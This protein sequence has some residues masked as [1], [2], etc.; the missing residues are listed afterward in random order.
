[1]DL[2]IDDVYE[3]F[4]SFCDDN[5]INIVNLL[6]ENKDA[7]NVFRFMALCSDENR[8]IQVDDNTLRNLF[9]L[10]KS[11]FREAIKYLEDNGF[12]TISKVGSF[13]LYQINQNVKPKT[14]KNGYQVITLKADPSML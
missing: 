5:S 10:S 4:M 2:I 11:A 7:F 1:M 14:D 12:V 6:C 9:G 3:R 8:S 13:N